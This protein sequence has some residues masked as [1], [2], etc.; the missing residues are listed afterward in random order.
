MRPLLIIKSGEKLPS[1]A[2]TPGDYEDWIA[3]GM[4]L[5]DDEVRV[6]AP[7][8]G[9]P[10]PPPGEVCGAVITGSGA[11]V[12]DRDGWIE[13]SAAWL[14]GAHRQ[15]MPLLGICFGHQL[16]A[17]AL[18]GEVDYNPAGVEVGTV[19]ITLNNH[20]LNDPLLGA[21]PATFPAQLS[22]RQS[23]RTLPPQ[24]RLLATSAMEPHQAFHCGGRCWGIQF[25]P[26][27]DEAI[28]A[29]FIDYYRAQLRQEGRTTDTLLGSRRPA[30]ES[31]SL[32]T[33][34]AALVRDTC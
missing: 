30:H 7:Y 8:R 15:G 12:T 3:S 28:I 21:L 20:G 22:H 10:L 13:T 19:D 26:E 31:H 17:H 2:A 32:L 25:H 6:V 27:F 5:G 29:H 18:G 9:E 14:R 23:V 34:F 24:A 33:R 16:L 4:G 11:M 1:L